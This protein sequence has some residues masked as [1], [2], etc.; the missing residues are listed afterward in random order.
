MARHP[1][2]SPD[3][4]RAHLGRIYDRMRSACLNRKYYGHKLHR[5][6]QLDFW[7]DL[8][9]ALGTSAAVAAW[10]LWHIP[11]GINPWTL[12]AGIAS[13]AALIKPLLGVSK[14]IQ[15]LA[16]LHSGYIR[17]YHDLHSLVEEIKTE[18]GLTQGFLDRFDEADRR[19]RDLAVD[20]DL[21]PIRRL[22]SKYE[23]EV[24]KEFPHSFFWNP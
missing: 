8:L 11:G 2:L 15:I 3:Q 1:H 22:A 10:T 24:R 18:Q 4:V 13:I 6:D 17:L 14:K 20:D 19:Y 12:L 16:K 7:S 21:K 23:D 5:Y 9:I